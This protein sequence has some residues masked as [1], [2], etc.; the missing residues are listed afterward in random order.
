MAG[1]AAP[2][3]PKNDVC[4]A[5]G[6]VD[7]DAVGQLDEDL[8]E[9]LIESNENLAN[10]DREIV[11]LERTPEDQSLISAVFRTI[12]TIK[13]TCGFFDFNCLGSVAHIAEN[14]LCQV[15]EEHRPLTPELISLILEAVDKIK[16]FLVRIETD[17]K[18]GEDD[19]EEL[20]FRLNEAHRAFVERT[21]GVSPAAAPQSHPEP[22]VEATDEHDAEAPPVVQSA[23]AVPAAAPQAAPQ[24]VAARVELPP[25]EAAVL[26]SKIVPA[27][28]S[29]HPREAKEISVSDPKADADK[30]AN[31]KKP[32]AHVAES[33][34]R[35]DVGLLNKLM[36]LVGELVLARN[37]LVQETTSLN[38][39]LLKTAQR[40]NLITSELQEGV[41]KT[42]MQP[43]GVV[44]NKLPRVVRDL[45]AKCGKT[46]QIEMQGAGTELD[47]TIIE[48]IKDPL[49]HI[50]RNSCDHGVELPEVRIAKGKSPEGMLL[51][52]AYHEGGVVN[53]EISDDGAGM[54]CEVLK[55]KAVE[56][57]LLRA[58][59]SAQMSDRD[60]RH[61]IFM[62]GFSTA[63]QVT[64]ISGR[65]VGMD[66]VKTNIEKIG[67][68]VDVLPREPYG[69]TI[70]IKIPLTLAI[71]P[72]LVVSLDPDPFKGAREQRFVVPQANLLELV[73][74]E[75][76]RD[77]QLIKNLHGTVIFH[78]R[79]SLLPLV[80][81]SKVLGK[82]APARRQEV[83]NIVV[84]Q[85]ENCQMGLVVDHI[86]DTQE[87]VVKPLGRQLKS[88]TCYVGATI[89]GDGHPA[90]ILDVVGLARL[91]GLGGQPRQ[92]IDK[93]PPTA[94]LQ[95]PQ[96]T[97]MLLLF[98]AG[99]F[100]R[101]AVPLSLVARLEEIATSKI[102]R[103]A[104]RTVLHYRGDILPLVCLSSVLEAHRASDSLS[105]DTAQVIV[106]TDGAR[107]AGVVVD[108]I[109][110]IVNEAITVRRSSPAPGLLGSAVIGGKITD[111][112]DLH[113]VVDRCGE[114]WLK[115][116]MAAGTGHKL[117]LLDPSV[118]SR[119]MI[120]EYLSAFGYDVISADSISDALPRMRKV[121][122]DL[123][124]AAVE[125]RGNKGI[126][127]LR[128]IR[129][130]K[131]FEHIPVL[132]LMEHDDQMRQ[133]AAGGLEFDAQLVRSD[134]G[135]LLDLVAA[136][137]R[138]QIVPHEVAA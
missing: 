132:G 69:S 87:I 79:G 138:S 57:G 4:V 71:I 83:V 15:R 114:N 11:E 128:S 116:A 98:R 109:V 110:D 89:M 107:R 19:A 88:L 72:G 137:V 81:L 51:L 14:I 97:Q 55:R 28:I 135:Q 115:P 30:K 112:L 76:E 63:A 59:Q 106:F 95:A 64:S 22:L 86:R 130:D 5:G 100:E 56:K 43:I 85:A 77:L 23:P 90:L 1:A 67:G 66:V 45:A 127:A 119:D 50:V 42:R 108:Q 47:K 8:K 134:R 13:G 105:G 99:S 91:A 32:D 62:P 70:R 120:S 65:G 131:Q 126:D 92:T 53:I 133:P 38:P 2:I 68:S 52:R 37:Q 111:L 21:S 17:G 41:M 16:A 24:P 33:T 93:L 9:F 58:E 27:P 35:V 48:A 61:L 102:E 29:E 75:A 49:T 94:G 82:S 125:A 129:Q 31:E 80:Y 34:I 84:V 96:E 40:L 73:R 104:G 10:L 12:H 36:N 101:L 25:R 39:T 113:A 46:V 117:L 118:P 3:K 20:R 60:A 123:V 74:L 121:P 26:E 122:I 103:A 7:F 44:W 78:H 18:E 136:L 124:I 6:S 54:N